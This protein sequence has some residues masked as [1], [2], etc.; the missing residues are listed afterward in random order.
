MVLRLRIP[1]PENWVGAKCHIIEV[2]GGYDPFFSD[3]DL[4]SE[5][6]AQREA[7]AVEFCNGT[8]DGEVCSIREGCALFALTNNERTGVWGGMPPGDRKLV[9][10][11]YP[12][13]NGKD[14]HPA[15]R[16]FSP[17]EL[18][19]LLSVKLEEGKI[20]IEQVIAE[21]EDEDD[22]EEI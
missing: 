6:N 22:D 1:A 16:W 10:K 9:R 21:D 18:M 19:H 14:P 5:E 13:R 8:S 7:E 15:W 3:D 20:N 2:T 12:K 17:S 11:I 4:T